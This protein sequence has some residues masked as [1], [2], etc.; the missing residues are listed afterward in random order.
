MRIP[1]GYHGKA[2]LIIGLFKEGLEPYLAAFK[3]LMPNRKNFRCSANSIGDDF[4]FCADL[5]HPVI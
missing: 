4:A 1:I 3:R 2:I 5:W